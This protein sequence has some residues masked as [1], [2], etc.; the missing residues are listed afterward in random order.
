MRRLALPALLVVLLPL[1]AA[2]QG[3]AD[4]TQFVRISPAIGIHYG[5]PLRLSLA[6]GGLFDFRGSRNDGVIAMAEPG[7]G[8]VELSL[9]YFRT[10]RFGQG[11]SLRLAGIRTSEEPWNTSARTTYLGVEAHWML[12]V[13]VGGRAGWFRRASA[14]GASD[15]DDNLGTIGLSIGW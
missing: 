7:Q 6:A 8:G 9:G 15:P 4:T 3:A 2:A 11:Y 13:G 14:N 10:R 5:A 1:R 12:L